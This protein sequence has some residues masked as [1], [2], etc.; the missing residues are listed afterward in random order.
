MQTWKRGHAL[1]HRQI[2]TAR[3]LAVLERRKWGLLL[4]SLLITEY[5]ERAFDLDTLLTVQMRDMPPAKQRYLKVAL[6]ESLVSVIHHLVSRG[7]GHRDFKA[8]NVIVQWDAASFDPPR[9]LLVDLDGVHKLRGCPQRAT[10]RMLARLNVSFDHCRRVTLTDR[11]RFL[12]RY[13][14][15]VDRSG[16]SWKQ[17][18]ERLAEFSDRKREIRDREQQRK[19]KKYG[20]F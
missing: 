3:P 7:F 1:L 2:P 13:L 20:R 10:W 17:I 16:T 9:I 6:T 11:A 12:K 15:R 4:D 14:Q 19:F 8:P 18:W 5:I